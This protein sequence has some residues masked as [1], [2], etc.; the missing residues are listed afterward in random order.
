M[1]RHHSTL[2]IKLSS[3]KI[4]KTVKPSLKFLW[5][6]VDLNMKLMK[7]LNG[8]NWTLIYSFMINVKLDITL[9]ETLNWGTLN[10]VP[11]NMWEYYGFELFPVLSL[12]TLVVAW[13]SSQTDTVETFQMSDIWQK[14]VA[15]QRLV[16]FMLPKIYY[17]KTPTNLSVGDIM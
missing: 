17:F 2:Y 13:A 16:D 6:A 1:F 12:E 4:L 9:H 3:L 5:G 8:S 10:R 7:I 14:S 15:M 11:L